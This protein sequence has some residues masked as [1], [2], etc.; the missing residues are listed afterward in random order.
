MADGTADDMIFRLLYLLFSLSTWLWTLPLSIGFCDCCKKETRKP[1]SCYISC[2]TRPSC[3]Y[4]FRFVALVSVQIFEI[5]KDKQAIVSSQ[6]RKLSCWDVDDSEVSTHSIYAKEGRTIW[7]KYLLILLEDTSA[8][9]NTHIPQNI[10]G[11][12]RKQKYFLSVIWERQCSVMHWFIVYE[13]IWHSENER[14]ERLLN[15]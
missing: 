10:R 12:L 6:E 8:T 7:A 2:V 3:P 9:H 4:N 5:K 15:C 14:F 11:W 1:Q 13:K